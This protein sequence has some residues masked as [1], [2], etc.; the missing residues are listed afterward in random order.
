MT[1]EPI[2]S[3]Q[4]LA[5]GALHLSPRDVPW[6]R[7]GKH[8]LLGAGSPLTALTRAAASCPAQSYRNARIGAV[9][10]ARRAGTHPAPKATAVS[11]NTAL[12]N[13]KGSCPSSP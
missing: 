6:A 7:T 2:A 4:N 12:T 13:T 8:L 10:L 11:S 9:R 3:Q 5:L 1:G